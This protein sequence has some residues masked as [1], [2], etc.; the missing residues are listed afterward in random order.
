MLALAG[1]YFPVYEEREVRQ[2]SPRTRVQYA[3]PMTRAEVEKLIKAGISDAVIVEKA[4]KTGVVKLSADDIVAL[5]Q[6]GASDDLIKEL[7]ANER[8]ATAE[9]QV[10]TVPSTTAYYTYYDYWWGPSLGLGYY[11]YYDYC[12]P[13][14]RYYGSRSRVGVGV[15]VGW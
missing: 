14:Y 12:T 8:R 9:Q 4:K 6:A 13:R 3:D 10:Y 11:G 15:R 1:C 7:I 2:A 5:K